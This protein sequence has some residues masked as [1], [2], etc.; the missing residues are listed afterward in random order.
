MLLHYK[1]STFTIT[2]PLGATVS[3]IFTLSLAVKSAYCTND[4]RYMYVIVS[5]NVTESLY[6]WPLRC[7]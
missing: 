4:C 6:H 7:S 3:I 2:V 5:L 1:L